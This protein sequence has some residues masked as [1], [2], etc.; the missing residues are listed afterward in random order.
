MAL[1]VLNWNPSNEHTSPFTNAQLAFPS[2]K[3][4]LPQHT[5][6][7]RDLAPNRKG[8]LSETGTSRV[9]RPIPLSSEPLVAEM[10]KCPSA[11]SQFSLTSNF[12]CIP[13]LSNW[14]SQLLHN[15]KMFLGFPLATCLR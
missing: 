6:K 9:K 8:C 13:A 3:R 10:L 12:L 15:S 7:G 11:N 14:L 5:T 2:A 1:L 4:E